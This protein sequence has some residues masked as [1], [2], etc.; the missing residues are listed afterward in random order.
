[1]PDVAPLDSSLPDV[2]LPDVALPDVALPDLALPDFALPDAALPDLALPDLM[3][4][5]LTLPDLSLPDAA[6]PDLELPDFALPDLALPD[7]VQPDLTLPDLALPDLVQPDFALPDLTLPDLA[8][9][10][11]ALPDL[12]QPDMLVPDA[13]GPVCEW[14]VRRKLSFKNSGQSTD[15]KDFPVL[16]VFQPGS[17]VDYAKTQN[18]GQDIRFTEADGTTAIPHEIEVWDESGASFVW[19]KVPQIDGASNLDHIWVYY[20]NGSVSDGQTPSQVWDASYRGVWHLNDVPDGSSADVQDSTSLGGHGTS[21]GGM[22]APD[23]VQGPVGWCLDFDGSDDYVDFGD[24]QQ[25]DLQVY[26]WSMWLEANGPVVVGSGNQQPIWNADRIFNFSWG[27]YGSAFAQAAAHRDSADWRPAQIASSLS[28]ST[29]YYIAGT[30]D[31][32]EITVYLN[33]AAEDTATA[34]TPLS[35]TGPLTIGGPISGGVRFPGRLDEVRVSNVA[36]KPDW[37]KA[38]YLSMTDAFIVYGAEEPAAPGCPQ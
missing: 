22:G 13:P 21:Q 27:H 16:V 20:G 33:G 34:G 31:G 17:S 19:V 38:Q 11:L 14:S 32:T 30:Y 36:R 15:L 7:L 6:L 8:L 25:F 29:W 24:R 23:Q 9:P 10:D 2:A 26:S 18:A 4:P 5:D 37:I 1:L 28:A 12:V 3:L 35:A